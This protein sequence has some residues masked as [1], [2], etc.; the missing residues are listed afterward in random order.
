MKNH[1]TII[2]LILFIQ[3]CSHFQGARKLA[4]T[5]EDETFLDKKYNLEIHQVESLIEQSLAWRERSIIFYQNN[6]S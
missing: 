2:A 3:S 6:L 4:S 1:V 5:K